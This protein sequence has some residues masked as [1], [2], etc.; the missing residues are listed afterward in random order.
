MPGAERLAMEGALFGCVPIISSRWVGASRVDYPGVRRVDHQNATDIAA[1]LAHVAANYEKELQSK[2]R[3]GLFLSHVLSM[4]QKTFNSVERVVSSTYIH[5]LLHARTLEEE[6]TATFQ[7]L[8]ILYVYPM[9]SIDLY[10][11]DPLWFMRHHYPFLRLLQESGYVQFDPLRPDGFVEYHARQRCIG[12]RNG[13]GASTCVGGG[14]SCELD[15][16]SNDNSLFNVC[17]LPLLNTNLQK[18]GTEK[19][20]TEPDSIASRPKKLK[21]TGLLPSWSSVLVVLPIGACDSGPSTDSTVRRAVSHLTQEEIVVVLGDSR[22]EHH[23]KSASDPEQES[24]PPWQMLVA[25]P[26]SSAVDVARIML[27][28]LQLQQPRTDTVG[29]NWEHGVQCSSRQALPVT[30]SNRQESMKFLDINRNNVT[31]FSGNNS[32]IPV[33]DIVSNNVVSV[34]P[35][36]MLNGIQNSAAWQTHKIFT[37][38]LGYQC[39]Q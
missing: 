11:P 14:S 20:I 4:W 16:S 15:H 10:V 3:T 23:T 25:D 34:S 37:N 8:A 32:L 31:C 6:Y 12:Q 39:K 9:A 26:D 30:N 21:D 5:F 7:I 18:Y 17:P 19:K 27:D 24:L 33:C 29:R 36:S 1:A 38:A 2:E 28:I 22:F 35:F 13:G